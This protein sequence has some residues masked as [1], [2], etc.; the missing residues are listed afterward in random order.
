MR[1]FWRNMKPVHLYHI[2]FMETVRHWNIFYRNRCDRAVDM[3]NL[4]LELYYGR[5][6]QSHTKKWTAQRN[7][8]QAGNTHS[9]IDGTMA[10][11]YHPTK[12][13]IIC[14]WKQWINLSPLLGPRY[15]SSWLQK[16][17]DIGWWVS[18][19]KRKFLVCTFN[20]FEVCVWRGV[21]GY[22]KL[23][24]SAGIWSHS[25]GNW[26]KPQTHHP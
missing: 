8:I 12:Y 20:F 21:K 18:I 22:V 1:A 25:Y 7:R 11:H 17:P 26:R 24:Y 13:H 5:G 14:L 10:C 23:Q 3:N 9:F 2:S 19:N 4:M 6:I 16:K 15:D